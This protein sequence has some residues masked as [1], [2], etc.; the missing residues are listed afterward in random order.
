MYERIA[1]VISETLKQN[2][3]PVVLAGDHSTGA[4][5]I[6]GIKKAK[7]KNKLGVVWIDAHADMHSPYTTH[8]GNMHG[9]P[10][11]V[12]LNEDNRENQINTLNENTIDCWNKM[13]T[14]VGI[15]PMILPENLVFIALRDYE[16]EEEAIIKKHNI[17]V[18]SVEDVRERGAKC[19]VQ[20]TLL[21]LKNCDD[22]YI[23]FDVDSLD[24]SVSIGTGISVN[25]G[26]YKQEAEDLMTGF[27]Q[28][29]K[30]CCFEITEINP[31]LD[32]QN[33]M[34][35]T[36]FDILQ[37]SVDVFCCGG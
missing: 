37:K 14:V 27:M 21:Y 30:T 6:A 10:I 1:D 11:A 5:T 36:V 31:A 23:S 24:S 32:N 4:G 25:N 18:F 29:E 7:P 34:A 28:N 19:V 9:M 3:F 20:E 8:S 16:K 22:I 35:K 2:F 26:L 17:K 33:S 12:A 15:C 13:K